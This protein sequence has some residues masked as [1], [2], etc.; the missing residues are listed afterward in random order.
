MGIGGFGPRRRPRAERAPTAASQPA[1]R[2]GRPD[3]LIVSSAYRYRLYGL[4]IASPLVL[5]CP[6]V[7]HGN[8]PDVLLTAGGAA[9]FARVRA[10]LTAAGPDGQDYQLTCARLPDGTRYLRWARLFEFIVS[11]DGRHVWYRGLE[12]ASLESFNTYLLGA[13]LSFSLLALGIEP[14]HGSAAV[15]DGHAVV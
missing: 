8:K 11:P 12:D 1:G 10:G 14:L 13:V 5:A 15:I 7:D 6:R 9:R 2:A 3:K 4:T